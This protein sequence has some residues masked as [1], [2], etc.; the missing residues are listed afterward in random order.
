MP[1]GPELFSASVLERLKEKGRRDELGTVTYYDGL[2]A[3]EP[4]ALVESFAGEPEL[5]DVSVEDVEHIVTERGGSA[6]PMWVAVG[7]ARDEPNDVRR[8]PTNVPLSV[9]HP[10]VVA[11]LAAQDPEADGAAVEDRSRGLP[12]VQGRTGM[13][14]PSWLRR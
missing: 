11:P 1:W 5:H 7:F 12:G 10:P 6:G 8:H 2:M 4:D 3:R 9:R 13:I 14:T